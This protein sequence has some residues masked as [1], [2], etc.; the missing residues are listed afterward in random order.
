MDKRVED[1]AKDLMNKLTPQELEALAYE[2]EIEAKDKY[3]KQHPDEAN[4]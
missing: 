2:L 3:Y 1:I 4:G